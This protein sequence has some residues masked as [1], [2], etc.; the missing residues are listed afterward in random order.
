ML[1]V[2]QEELMRRVVNP[3]LAVA[4]VVAA[5][6]PSASMA[7]TTRRVDRNITINLEYGTVLGVE[8]VDLKSRAASGAALGGIAG[9]AVHHGDT[10]DNLVGAAAGAALGA[11]LSEAL[12]KHKAYAITI[13]LLEGDNVEVILNKT[14][15]RAGDCVALEQGNTT[16]VRLVS[17]EMCDWG[18]HHDD[19]DVR[20]SHARVADECHQA[21]LELL[22]A[23]E[24]EA[25]E[26]ALKK[27]DIL[28]H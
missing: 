9:L 28:C 12:A 17:A 16:N 4:L 11:L 8:Q 27:V 18:P 5:A 1:Q 13:D 23:E 6:V 2:N 10:E 14:D 24:P 21:K 22:E 26:R 19:A 7:Q 20:A 3:V 15:V 25:F